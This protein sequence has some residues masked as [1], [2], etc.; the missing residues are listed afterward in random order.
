MTKVSPK[1]RHS[2]KR[3]RLLE[4]LRSL[5][6]K[7]EAGTQLP[8]YT[9][10]CRKFNVCQST[11]NGVLAELDQSN[12]IERRPWK[13]IYVSSRAK[14]KHIGLVFDRDVFAPGSSPVF[15]QF[16]HEAK[17]RAR[18][19]NAEVRFYIDTIKEHSGMLT[20]SDVVAD[21]RTGKLDGII[22]LHGRSDEEVR[23]FCELGIPLAFFSPDHFLA[24]SV[25]IDFDG[26]IAD[27]VGQLK[28]IGC[29]SIGLLSHL[30]GKFSNLSDPTHYRDVFRAALRAHGL[31]PDDDWIIEESF[32]QPVDPEVPF[33]PN[34]ERGYY[35]LRK[36]LGHQT[37]REVKAY[38]PNGLVIT[39]DMVTRGVLIALERDYGLKVGTDI[40]IATYSNRNS[41]ALFGYDNHLE[42]LEID[43]ALFVDALFRMVEGQI[44]G[45]KVEECVFIK[46]QIRSS[47]PA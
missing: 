16:I 37:A 26:L 40:Q 28:K 5:I 10:M 33:V 34:E 41:S 6:E 14:Q 36:K 13:G 3:T 20:H 2:S 27:G 35:M 23:F 31:R 7:S 24:N 38:V 4:G 19:G 32:M 9:E 12:L 1:R 30:S 8:S 17:K 47:R 15:S 42:H 25:H 11:I 44:V 45:Q 39:D 21:V 46:P 29:D 18:Q 22:L 43:L